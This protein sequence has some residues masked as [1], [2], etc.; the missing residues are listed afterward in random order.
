MRARPR[1]RDTRA[2]PLLIIDNQM[3][4]R[5]PDRPYFFRRLSNARHLPT[6]RFKVHSICHLRCRSVG[7]RARREETLCPDFRLLKMG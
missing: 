2:Y 7:M 3:A 4:M 1:G 5:A 6:M